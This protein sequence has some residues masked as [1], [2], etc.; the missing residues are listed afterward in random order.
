MNV[1]TNSHL[2]GGKI[3]DGTICLRR[4]QLFQAPFQVFQRLHGQLLTLLICI[5]AWSVYLLPRDAM[6]ARYTLSSCVVM[7]VCHTPVI[8]WQQELSPLGTA[9][10]L[11]VPQKL[12][13]SLPPA[14]RDSSDS[15]TVRQPA[16]T[17]L[18]RLAYGRASWLLKVGV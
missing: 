14:L 17:H 13:N 10:S 1:K 7:S 2:V 4:F 18:F 5:S 6:L 15:D 8:R 12:W 11:R 9:V 16:K 3:T